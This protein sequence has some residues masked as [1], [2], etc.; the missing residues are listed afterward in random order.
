MYVGTTSGDIL[1]MS[2]TSRLFKNAGPAKTRFPRG[3]V[4]SAISP[5]GEIVIG[6]GDGS[7]A[8][9]DRDTMKTI[10][11]TK[12]ASGVTSCEIAPHLH[13]D[14]GFGVYCG[15]DSCEV[16]YLKFSPM[17]GFK[18]ELIQTCHHEIINDIAFPVGYSEVFITAGSND[19]RVWHVNEARELLRV[20][21]PNVTCN[22]VAF[23]PDGGS[24]IS[25]WS[26]GKIRAFAPQSGRLL[27]QINDAHGA[28]TAIVG[29]SDCARIITGGEEGNVRVWRIGPQSQ[30]MVAS[31]KEHKGPVNS[32]ALRAN[33]SEC[34]SASSDGSCVV[35]DLAR[36]SRNMSLNANTFFK[37][38]GYHPDESQIVTAG[39]DRQLSWWD[40]FDGQAIRVVDGSNDAEI[41]ALDISV[42][43]DAIVIGGGDKE[44]KVFGYDEGHCARVG[45]GHSGA[46]TKVKFTPDGQRI[47]T[48]G[49]EGAIFIWRNAPLE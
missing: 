39:T 35:W 38:V 22:C 14:G 43:G 40:A 11:I 15:T 45:R 49:A 7:V 21:V 20:K 23:M 42:S 13:E 48:V 3:V 36:F 33:D 17:E 10:A 34:V 18:S 26:D 41:N 32:L 8:L 47:V 2:L 30:S 12:L 31:M 1:Q 6:G 46:I 24:I 16:Y 25:G 28:V 5:T 9:L 29:S 4:S 44:V 27:Y 19:V 37:A